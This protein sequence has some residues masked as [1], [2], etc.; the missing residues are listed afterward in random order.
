VLN[1][2][3]LA[4]RRHGGAHDLRAEMLGYRLMPEAHSKQRNA[5]RKVPYDV[6]RNASV[7]WSAR[8]RRKNDMG[9]LHR[10]DIVDSDR[11]VSVHAYQSTQSAKGLNEVVRKRVVIVDNEKHSTRPVCSEHG[12]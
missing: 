10:F 1:V 8:P 11:V 3:D 4:M 2:R 5:P 12:S 9:R 6:Q 7:A